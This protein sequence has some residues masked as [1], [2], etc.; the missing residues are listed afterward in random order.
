MAVKEVEDSLSVQSEEQK[1]RTSLTSAVQSRHSAMQEVESLYHEGQI[2]KLALLDIQRLMLTSEIALMDNE[3][4]RL[5]ADVQLYKALGGGWNPSQKVSEAES[6]STKV[7][8]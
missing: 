7:L 1:R 4:N 5:L 6:N 2:D 3:T 8:P